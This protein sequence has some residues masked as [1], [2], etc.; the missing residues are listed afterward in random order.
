MKHFKLIHLLPSLLVALGII[1]A[2]LAMK[3]GLGW[4][5]VFGPVVL[6]VFIV[7][8][9]LIDTR[10][11]DGVPATGVVVRVVVGSILI[12]CTLMFVDDPTRLQQMV[13]ILGAMAWALL[14]QRLTARRTC[15]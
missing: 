15:D 2:T 7:V 14:L 9:C 1:L 6:G 12:V 8:A 5:T 11:H 13:P 10:V 3:T 4:P